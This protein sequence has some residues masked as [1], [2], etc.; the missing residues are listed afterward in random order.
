MTEK[1]SPRPVEEESTSPSGNF[2]LPSGT[3]VV[4]GL[5]IALAVSLMLIAVS[6]ILTDEGEPVERDEVGTGPREEVGQEERLSAA[7][8]EAIVLA[9]ESAIA[10]YREADTAEVRE[11]L[12]FIYSHALPEQLALIE[13]HTDARLEQKVEEYL[14]QAGEVEADALLSDE[15]RWLVGDKLVEVSCCGVEEEQ[16][17]FYATEIEGQWYGF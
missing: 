9:I 8:K 2:V 15:A 3:S 12:E 5:V 16:S 6:F 10:D 7:D 14:T 17:V 1:K 4:V 11:Y 13:G